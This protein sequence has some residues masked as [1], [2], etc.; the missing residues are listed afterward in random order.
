MYKN[1]GKN[2]SFTNPNAKK[3][4]FLENYA[5]EKKIPVSVSKHEL[6][7]KK[8]PRENNPEIFNRLYSAQTAS[9]MS[10]RQPDICMKEQE[11]YEDM[12]NYQL[13]NIPRNIT[14]F[15]DLSNKET[16]SSSKKKH[17]EIDHSL[18]ER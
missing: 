17:N 11:I 15:Q 12:L 5:K 9:F 14:H 10:K 6:S 1:K 3:C 8:S 2:T 7:F 13:A 16:Y 18:D 4:L